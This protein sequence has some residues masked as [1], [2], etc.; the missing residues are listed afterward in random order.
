M[1][2]R[3]LNFYLE[4]RSFRTFDNDDRF[5]EVPPEWFGDYKD[6]ESF[7]AC[8]YA[9]NRITPDEFA[10][11]MMTTVLALQTMNLLGKYSLSSSWMAMADLRDLAATS[12]V[13]KSGCL[14]V[15]T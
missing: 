15:D 3:L 2:R 4:V 10:P 9:Y 8:K 7:M 1:K 11:E 6:Y 5:F 13:E 14:E 12:V